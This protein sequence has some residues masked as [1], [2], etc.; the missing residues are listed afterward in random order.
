MQRK[1]VGEVTR[2]HIATLPANALIFALYFVASGSVLYLSGRTDTLVPLWP[3]AGLAL[4]AVSVF[5]YRVAPAIM[6]A[7]FC[8]LISF[9]GNIS[10]AGALAISAGETLG[11]VIG[12]AAVRR[13]GVRD[14]FERVVSLLLFFVVAGLPTVILS[15]GTSLGVE[16][17]SGNLP[18]DRFIDIG[19]VLFLGE[20]VGIVTIWPL[21][22]SWW[23]Y[24]LPVR[25]GLLL[26]IISLVIAL[27]GA[28]LWFDTSYLRPI[29]ILPL[30]VWAALAFD[31]RGASLA[32]ALVGVIYSVELVWRVE[33]ALGLSET[34]LETAYLQQRLFIMASIALIV[35]A[36]D[37]AR[38]KNQQDRLALAADAAG[39]GFFEA[40]LKKGTILLDERIEKILELPASDAPLKIVSFLNQ[41]H[42][43][44][45]AMLR[46]LFLRS[47]REDGEKFT[48]EPRIDDSTGAA[49][50]WVAIN[51]RITHERHGMRGVRIVARGSVREITER[52]RVE[53]RVRQHERL[54]R[55]ILDSLS[56]WVAVVGPDGTVIETNEGDFSRT[57]RSMRG[58]LGM[59]IWNEEWWNGRNEAASM[60]REAIQAATRNGKTS[61]FDVKMSG[62]AGA[63]DGSSFWVDLQVAPLIDAPISGSVVLSGIDITARREAEALSRRLESTIE[64]TPDY[65]ALATPDGVPVFLNPGGRRLLSNDPDSDKDHSDGRDPVPPDTPNLLANLDEEARAA[66]FRD[67]LWTGE[68]ILSLPDGREIPVS[69]VLVAHSEEGRITALSTIMR[70]MSEQKRN[71]E[72]Q[73]LLLRELSHRVKNTLAVIQ[74]MA[75]QTLRTAGSPEAFTESF[76]GRIASLSASH[77]LLTERDWASP[78]LR[79]V[80]HSQLR[81]LLGSDRSIVI[82]GPRVR[83]P[84]ETAT[85]FGLVIHELGTN[86]IKHGVLASDDGSLTI[87]WTRSESRRLHF[88]WKETGTP[89]RPPAEKME[90]GF[91]TRLLQMTA[92]DLQQHLEQDGLRV[93]FDLELPEGAKVIDRD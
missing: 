36:I 27:T 4:A 66:L 52:K 15:A 20:L 23:R 65:V 22:E 61:R 3:A 69:Q 42:S 81:P 1:F 89:A 11:P 2:R 87:Q 9:G 57:A 86:A 30:I 55:G 70:D 51:G 13:I 10:I 31:V 24:G 83:L 49:H 29:H 68:N 73:A 48:I 50:R 19:I 6:L 7:S 84:A 54:L 63:D 76:L 74:G 93:T 28:M 38:Q 17:V 44:D 59:K 75:R 14:P 47:D 37:Y 64:G 71:I 12:I 79:Q 8:S 5:G 41:L 56:A 25:S 43:D 35:G 82:E 33:T 34:L 32:V 58:L 39:L 88:V 18:M 21:V 72:R 91:G 46:P 16:L 77:A 60:V 85:Q 90:N 53:R 26:L 78:S 62:P 92:L 45:A 67:K 40:N 80:I